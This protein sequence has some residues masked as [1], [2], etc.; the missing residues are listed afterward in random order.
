MHEAH[1]EIA[2]LKALGYK[3]VDI[4]EMLD[5]SGTMVSMVINSPVV[6]EKI[7][8]LV[9]A[10]DAEAVDILTEIRNKAP[11]A[12][13]ILGDIVDGDLNGVKPSIHLQA[14]EANNILDRAG[15]GAVKQVRQM[16]LVAHLTAEDID[17]IKQRAI[18]NGLKSGDIIDISED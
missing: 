8:Q 11:K 16:G 9:A 10:R 6:S 7:D 15:Y 14:K 13:K 12:L 2:R 17:Q 4:A 3:N 5:I 1:H 18:M